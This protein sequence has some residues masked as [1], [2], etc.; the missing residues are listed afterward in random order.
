M[1]LLSFVMTFFK[2]HPANYL[3]RPNCFTEAAGP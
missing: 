3:L 2:F 1:T